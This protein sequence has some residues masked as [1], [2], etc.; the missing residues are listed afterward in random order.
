MKTKWGS[1][2]RRSGSIWFNVELA[3]KYPECLEYIVV[4]EMTHH[5]ERNHT[6]RFTRLMDAAMPDWRARRDRL[7]DS[8]LSA[9]EWTAAM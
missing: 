8:P 6:E 1:C 4:H 3:K 9:E 2:N 7:N 5:R